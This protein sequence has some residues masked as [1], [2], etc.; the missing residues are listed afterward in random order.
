MT[1]IDSL[2]RRCPQLESQPDLGC[3]ALEQV[4]YILPLYGDER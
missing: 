2:E 1:A 3:F 4:V